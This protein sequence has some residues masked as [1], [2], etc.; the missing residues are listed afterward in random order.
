MTVSFGDGRIVS[1]RGGSGA[2]ELDDDRFYFRDP[3]ANVGQG[4]VLA[5]HAWRVTPRGG[6]EAGAYRPELSS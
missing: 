5:P 2:V 6:R 1:V 4:F 3:V